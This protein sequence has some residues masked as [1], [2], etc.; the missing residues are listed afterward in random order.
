MCADEGSEVQWVVLNDFGHVVGRYRTEERARAAIARRR[1]NDKTPPLSRTYRGSFRIYRVLPGR[2]VDETY[3]IQVGDELRGTMTADFTQ[4][5]SA[6]LIDG[7]STVF[8]VA[9]TSHLPHRAARMVNDWLRDQ[10]GELWSADEKHAVT[11]DGERLTISPD[12][13]L[14]D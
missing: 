5:S 2:R 3:P 9:D 14:D 8:Q 12:E 1:D 4:A 6:I 13:P 11:I 10:G 7:E